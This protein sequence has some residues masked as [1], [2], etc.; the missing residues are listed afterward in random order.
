ME[1]RNCGWGGGLIS[2]FV[3]PQPRAVYIV[4]RVSPNRCGKKVCVRLVSLTKLSCIPKMFGGFANDEQNWVCLILF[5]VLIINGIVQ[6]FKNTMLLDCCLGAGSGWKWCFFCLK[7]TKLISI[8][9]VFLVVRRN[10]YFSLGFSSVVVHRS[11]RFVRITI[12]LWNVDCWRG[13]GL[14]L[15]FGMVSKDGFE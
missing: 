12:V 9:F 13:C 14:H 11:S 2:A 8:L 7:G 15:F 5:W 3:S 1:K 6:R 4:E 10:V